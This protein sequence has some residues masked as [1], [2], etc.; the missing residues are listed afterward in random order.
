MD[1]YIIALCSARLRRTL[2]L[3]KLSMEEVEMHQCLEAKFV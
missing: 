2:A 3:I 1:T